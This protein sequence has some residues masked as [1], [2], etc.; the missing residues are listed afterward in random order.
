LNDDP[1]SGHGACVVGV[2]SGGPAASGGLKPGDLIL[3]LNGEPIQTTRQLRGIVAGMSPGQ[4]ADLLV[5]RAGRNPKVSVVL[6]ARP[7]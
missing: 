5:L 1:N 3:A 7:R 4:R 2:A 6:G